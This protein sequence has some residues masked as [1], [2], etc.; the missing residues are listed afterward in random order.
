MSETLRVAPSSLRS[1]WVW[2]RYLRHC[3]FVVAL[4]AVAGLWQLASIVANNRTL[5]PPPLLVLDAWISLWG[6]ELPTDI[7]ASLVHP[8]ST[9][10]HSYGTH[11]ICR[12]SEAIMQPDLGTKTTGTLV[13]PI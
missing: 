7:I 5:V 6:E 4:A 11:E 3:E 10:P 9:L 2:P 13:R 1:R 8:S 12:C